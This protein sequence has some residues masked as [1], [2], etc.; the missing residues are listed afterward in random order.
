MCHTMHSALKYQELRAFR[1]R[2]ESPLPHIKDMRKRYAHADAEKNSPA[3]GTRIKEI[4]NE[5][6]GYPVQNHLQIL[7]I[8]VMTYNLMFNKPVD[9]WIYCVLPFMKF[10]CFVV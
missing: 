9:D 4:P 2:L 8:E 5:K 3:C 1:K 6:T 7:V 10:N